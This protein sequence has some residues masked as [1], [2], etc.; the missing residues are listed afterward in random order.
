MERR[1]EPRYDLSGP[2][3]VTLL[4]DNPVS[5]QGRIINLSGRGMRVWLPQ[6]VPA[7]AAVRVDVAGAMFLGE[8]CYCNPDGNGYAAGFQLEHVLS[9]SEEL[10]ALMRALEQSVRSSA[11]KSLEDGRER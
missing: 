8:V 9:M 7:G 1:S 5:L 11:T 2:A 6:A 10:A 3:D 4:T